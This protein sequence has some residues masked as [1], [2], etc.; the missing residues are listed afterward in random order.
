MARW[1]LRRGG[2]YNESTRMKVTIFLFALYREKAGRNRL[3]VD[4]PEGATAGDAVRRVARDVPP[5]GPLLATAALAV[6]TE[7]AGPDTRL[8][9]GD[10]LALIP[11]VSGGATRA[12][13]V[14]ITD[15]PI[16]VQAA[17]AGLVRPTDGALVVFQ[18]VVRDFTDGRRLL[19]MDYE[20]YRPM[21]EKMLWHI[22]EEV[23]A[24]FR[25]DD[26][27]I[28]HRV[29]RLAVGEASL[30]V[31]VASPHRREAFAACQEAIDRVKRLAPVWKKEVWEGGEAWA[32]EE[33]SHR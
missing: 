4:L 7:Y 1:T 21:A 3:E 31:A 2:A 30:L 23:R 29:G 22:A 5:L 24:Q 6:N 33:H 14:S 11:P 16:N 28:V 13:A 20:A 27:A 18:G 15:Q 19:Y 8:R 25:V 12:A 9:D 32:T 10:E 26:V 17:I